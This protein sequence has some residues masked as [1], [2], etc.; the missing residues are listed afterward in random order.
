MRQDSRQNAAGGQKAATQKQEKPK[1]RPEGRPLHEIKTE[2]GARLM[3]RGLV[4]C[5]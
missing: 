5:V 1:N 4:T 3:E 2:R